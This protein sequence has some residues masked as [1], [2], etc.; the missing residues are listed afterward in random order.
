MLVPAINIAPAADY[1]SIRVML[2]PSSSLIDT[3]A[4]VARLDDELSEYNYRRGDSILMIGD[5]AIIAITGAIV[6]DYTDK[7]RLLKWEREQSK[8][9]MVEVKLPCQNSE[10]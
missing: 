10:R 7:F 9:I 4:A 6:A 5:P 3:S 8:Y 2:P 1:G